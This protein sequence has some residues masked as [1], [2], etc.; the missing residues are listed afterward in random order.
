MLFKFMLFSDWGLVV[1]FY[2]GVGEK[3]RVLGFILD[4]LKGNLVLI[5]FLGDCMYIKV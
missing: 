1:G 3:Y 4:I 2:L 5:R